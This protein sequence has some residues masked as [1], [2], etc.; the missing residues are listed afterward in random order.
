MGGGTEWESKRIKNETIA[1]QEEEKEIIYQVQ[2]PDYIKDWTPI[3]FSAFILFCLAFGWQLNGIHVFMLVINFI[4][5]LH[6][7]VY[8][9]SSNIIETN[10]K[11]KEYKEIINETIDQKNHQFVYRKPDHVKDWSPICFSIVILFSLVLGCEPN[12]I[13]VFM[14]MVTGCFG[15][16]YLNY[17]LSSNPITNPIKKK[18][19]NNE[20]KEIMN[21]LMARSGIRYKP[22]YKYPSLATFRSFQSMSKKVEE[23]YLQEITN[24]QIQGHLYVG[25][26][27]WFLQFEPNRIEFSVPI[28]VCE[29]AYADIVG[30]M[31][32][33][34]QATQKLK[35]RQLK[36]HTSDMAS[37]LN[38]IK[39]VFIVLR[40]L[41]EL[42]YSYNNLTISITND[43]PEKP[44]YISTTGQEYVLHLSPN[45]LLEDIQTELKSI[46]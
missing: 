7:L 11:Q 21:E 13:H 15:F 43:H 38:H 35:L 25:Y 27:Q 6:C 19:T 40:L 24:I 2:R 5:M 23:K 34:H 44:V 31:K 8:I 29:Q 41:D 42:S 18:E 16:S 9:L 10:P 1:K 20:Y 26:R 45:Y 33:I 14:F 37:F 39:N 12:G 46:Q 32:P 30:F 28:F 3:G 17:I 22:M 4:F 36:I